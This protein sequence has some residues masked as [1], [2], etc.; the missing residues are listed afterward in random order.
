[1]ASKEQIQK[2]LDEL[3]TRYGNTLSMLNDSIDKIDS[4]DKEIAKLKQQLADGKD[5]D[6][7]ISTPQEILDLEKSVLNRD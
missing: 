1:M 3:W 6:I 7:D 2:A 4:K 5:I